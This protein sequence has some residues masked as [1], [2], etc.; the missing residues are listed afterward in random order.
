MGWEF[1]G[2]VRT[3]GPSYS[4]TLLW[5]GQ[6]EGN[7]GTRSTHVA[8]PRHLVPGH[9][10]PRLVTFWASDSLLQRGPSHASTH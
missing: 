4:P 6:Q 7:E 3:Y 2:S 8:I 5:P 10:I 9:S 1:S